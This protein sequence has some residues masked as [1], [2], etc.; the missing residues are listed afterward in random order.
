VE[1][2]NSGR[3]NLVIVRAGDASLH[4][5]W[6][7]GPHA[8]TWDLV[9]SYFGDDPDRYRGD[10]VT[11]LDMKGAK[12]PGLHRAITVDLAEVIDRYDFVWLPDD[13]LAADTASIDALFEYCARH[14]LSLA[15]PALTEDS[16]FTHEITLVD[17]RFELRYTN[18]VEIMAPCFSR[19]F[20]TRCV[21]TF[22]GTHSGW[23]LDNHWPRMTSDRSSVAVIDA[24]TVRHTRPVGGPNGAAVRAAGT[25]PMREFREYVA[26]HG[27]VDF[28]H[29]MYGAVRAS[30]RTS[31]NEPTAVC[32]TVDRPAPG[33][34]TWLAYHAAK[35]DL[36]AVYADDPGVR[37]QV[38]DLTEGQPVLVCASGELTD[39][40]AG[41]RE[42]ANIR[43]AVGQARAAGMTW[44]LPLGPDELFYD[45]GRRRWQLPGA[46][47]V[48]FLC[49]EAVPAHHPV[50]DPFHACTVFRVNGR[51]PFLDARSGRSAVR[52]GPR[53]IPADRHGFT[54]FDG[55]SGTVTA[56]VILRYPYPS[57]E[58][59]MERA[60]AMVSGAGEQARQFAQHS[61][62]LL[63]V[64]VAH[65]RLEGARVCFQAQIPSDGMI[66]QMVRTG[67]LTR[68]DP[69]RADRIRRRDD[70]E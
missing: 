9:V 13:D 21:P 65:R 19:H 62:A 26:A 50:D 4:E 51:S 10:E 59:W 22:V 14:R 42:I 64:A 69:M 57:F 45:D 11:R 28:T 7:A 47:H 5:Q 41:D 58:S 32:V 40:D 25:D 33:L 49:H 15:Q 3:R 31:A 56:P 67:E 1:W 12:W 36:I 17:R 6:L 60:E 29:R 48:T 2:T 20:L 34:A 61:R 70:R 27:L 55:A 23:G 52:V 35:V 63:Q 39:S 43:A 46:G 38:R 37:E 66:D 8:R 44:L 53:V 68:I 16:Y 54:G 24:V 30:G 18:F